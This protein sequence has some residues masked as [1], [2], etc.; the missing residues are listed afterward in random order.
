MN[1]AITR[2]DQADESVCLFYSTC[3]A[4]VLELIEK[5]T[6]SVVSMFERNREQQSHARSTKALQEEQNE[7]Q[8]SGKD[9]KYGER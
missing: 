3:E 7:S 6:M 8:S 4:V 2:L 1:S 9:E 5:K